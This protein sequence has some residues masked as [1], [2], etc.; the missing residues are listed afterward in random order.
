MFSLF[1]FILVQICASYV[2]I[3]LVVKHLSVYVAKKGDNAG[4]KVISSAAHFA[5]GGA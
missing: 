4:G 2:E 1:G 5:L 3:L